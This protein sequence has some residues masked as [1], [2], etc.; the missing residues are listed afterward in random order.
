MFPHAV[1]A[2]DFSAGG[3]VLIRSLSSLRALG[4]ERVTLVHALDVTYPLAGVV[5][6]SEGYALH[7]KK[8]KERVTAEGFEADAELLTGDPAREVPRLASN[9]NASLI[10]VGSRSHNKLF[11]AFLGS[12]AWGILRHVR[13]PVLVVRIEPGSAAGDE[14]FAS[15]TPRGFE[16]LVLPTDWSQTAERAFAV[17]ESLARHGAIRSFHLLHV[18]SQLDEA[19]TGKSTEAVDRKKLD[20]LAERLRASGAAA[21]E[22]E[23]PSGAPV[24]EIVRLADGRPGTLIVMGTHGRSFLADSFLGGVSREVVRTSRSAVLLVPAPG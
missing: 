4:T 14:P 21:V 5:D 1:V 7:L 20:A 12:V 2:V 11:N 18:R 6:Y 19:R 24:P 16:R 8:L 22:I 13:T 15:R 17:A 3:E 10:V 23:A 9:R